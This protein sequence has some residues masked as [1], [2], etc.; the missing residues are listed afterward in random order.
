MKWNKETLSR[1]EKLRSR[2]DAE[3]AKRTGQASQPPEAQDQILMPNGS[4]TERVRE[5]V[6]A[7]GLC[8][9]PGH[10]KFQQNGSSCLMCQENERAFQRG[11]QSMAEKAAQFVESRQ[12][13]VVLRYTPFPHNP[14]FDNPDAAKQIAAAIRSLAGS[15]V[16]GA[17]TPTQ[18]PLSREAIRRLIDDLRRDG[19]FPPSPEELEADPPPVMRCQA[20]HPETGQCELR[21]GHEGKHLAGYLLWSA[22]TPTL[23]VQP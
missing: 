2:V 1:L 13:D 10:F 14:E 3:I 21:A 15:S 20:S 12:I 18:P 8:G 9:V 16:L 5:I 19:E 4:F 11:Q 23:R 7:S 22:A 17:A 6:L